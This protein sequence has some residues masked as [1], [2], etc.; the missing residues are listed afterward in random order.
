M[1][2]QFRVEVLVVPF[3]RAEVEVED[4]VQ[5]YAAGSYDL[6]LRLLLDSDLLSMLCNGGLVCQ[7]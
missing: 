4:V 6:F 7:R 3:I 1:L 2:K 5:G